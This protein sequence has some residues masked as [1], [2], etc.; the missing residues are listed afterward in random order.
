M[1]YMM[2]RLIIQILMTACGLTLRVFAIG[3]G[4]DG[5]EKVDIFFIRIIRE[6]K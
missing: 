1:N 6:I 3:Q 2:K 4:N 5:I